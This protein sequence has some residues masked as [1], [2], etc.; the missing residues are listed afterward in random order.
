M[1]QVSSHRASSFQ[2]T[3][4]P[5]PAPRCSS[6]S[7]ESPSSGGRPLAP[8]AAGSPSPSLIEQRSSSVAIRST[9][10]TTSGNRVSAPG[11][12]PQLGPP[13]RRWG[14]DH[15]R[16][17]GGSLIE[18]ALPPHSVLAGHL[19]VVRDVDHNRVLPEPVT[20]QCVQQ[21]PHLQPR[22]ASAALRLGTGCCIV[23]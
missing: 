6:G 3:S 18:V 2:P 11:G 12:A 4:A 9:V 8:P 16:D 13:A 21:R 17:A 23:G 10:E 22:H 15:E 19:A 14:R 5:V 7:S 20:L 1:R